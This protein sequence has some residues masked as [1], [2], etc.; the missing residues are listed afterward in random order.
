VCYKVSAFFALRVVWLR[1]KGALCYYFKPG[2]GIGDLPA[3][4]L[5]LARYP[6]SF[7]KKN[8]RQAG[9]RQNDQLCTDPSA[10]IN[11][12]RFKGFVL[13]S[14]GSAPSAFATG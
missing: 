7:R 12:F 6:A 11:W 10:S 2:F 13:S 8:A 4:S 9:G 1:P 14:R 3:V 5:E